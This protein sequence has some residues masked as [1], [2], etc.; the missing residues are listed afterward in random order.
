MKDPKRLLMM[1]CILTLTALSLMVWS[2]FDP[3]PI[4]VITAMSLGQ[5]VGTLSLLLYLY[6]IWSDLRRPLSRAWEHFS[7][8]PPRP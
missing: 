2:I 3:R 8:R 6:V 4:P 1:S 5:V 7:T